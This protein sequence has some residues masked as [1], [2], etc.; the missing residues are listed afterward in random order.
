MEPE[1]GSDRGQSCLDLYR[2][3]FP[4]WAADY[5]E[6]IR[7][8][9]S[10]TGCGDRPCHPQGLLDALGSYLQKHEATFAED[11]PAVCFR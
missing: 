10:G 9:L 4:R 11:V 3:T 8:E 7:C 2:H 6:L 5:Q 1:S